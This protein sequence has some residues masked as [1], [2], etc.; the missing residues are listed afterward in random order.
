MRKPNS[1]AACFAIVL[2]VVFGHGALSQS[3]RTIRM[4]VPFPAGGPGDNLAR[5]LG[6]QIG[7]M[8]GST[9][10]IESRPGA[11]GRIGTEAVARAPS[12]GGTLL[13]VANNVLIEPHVRA[14]NYD[15][16]TSFEP[17]CYLTNQPYILGVWSRDEVTRIDDEGCRVF[18]PGTTDGLEGRLPS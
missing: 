6:E 17:V 11:S 18:R 1:V 10:V 4:V 5:L 2:L 14:V 12:D 8:R 16:F 13:I 15:P 3:S 7:R 9:I